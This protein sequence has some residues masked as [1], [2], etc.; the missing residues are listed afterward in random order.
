MADAT[1]LYEQLSQDQKSEWWEHSLAL[2]ACDGV[3]LA[4]GR[5]GIEWKA[6][7]WFQAL[8]GS[9]SS[10][11][12][13]R[14]AP[15]VGVSTWALLRCL[16]GC[17][18]GWP[19]GFIYYLPHDAYVGPFVRQKVDP[20]LEAT[21]GLGA[22]DGSDAVSI[23]A[24]GQAHGFFR[25]IDSPTAREIV[26]ADALVRDEFD[27]MEPEHTE[28]VEGRLEGSAHKIIMDIGI[29]SVPGWGIDAAFQGSTANWWTLT[30]TARKRDPDWTIEES[31][32][33]CAG[34]KKA[35]RHLACPKCGSTADVSSGRWVPRGK[36]GP[37]G[38]TF[39]A[40][41]NPY[42]DVGALL[43]K[44][45]SGKHRAIL[46]RTILG[47][48]GKE[49]G[50]FGLNAKELRGNLCAGYEQVSTHGGPTWAGA[51]VGAGAETSPVVVFERPVNGKPRGVHFQGWKEWSELDKIMAMFHVERMVIDALP[52]SRAAK[53][54]VKK[55]RGR[56]YMCYYRPQRRGGIKWDDR[57]GIVEVD[58]TETLDESHEP[59][60]TGGVELPGA[61]DPE[62]RRFAMECEGLHRIE[63]DL[64]NGSSVAI[65]ERRGPDHY[66]QAF[67]YCWIAMT[68]P[69][70]KISIEM[71]GPPSTS[72]RLRRPMRF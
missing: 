15:Q 55:W 54:F 26:G 21:P 62:V 2:W 60:Y 8:Y 6:R 22:P 20:I 19:Q 61:D 45:E 47:M 66:R 70:P 40:L 28:E 17:L 3:K 63:K 31:W 5:G 13:I 50:G 64:P 29:P 59:L 68:A 72:S 65:W 16:H 30:C 49:S 37:E 35:S 38:Y 58:R 4:R 9:D 39:N 25:G 52:D 7:P 33:S 1:P 34:G 36:E 57:N 24:V 53:A 41:M 56:A 71:V 51:D 48:P 10:H 43:N 14:K 23:K 32:P 67:N 11:T 44:W 42:A 12:I 18:Y 27:L 46:Q 69:R